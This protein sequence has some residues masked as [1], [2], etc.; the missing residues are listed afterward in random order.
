MALNPTNFLDPQST[1]ATWQGAGGAGIPSY[2]GAGFLY[3]PGVTSSRRPSWGQRQV[4][5]P[6]IERHLAMTSLRI[7]KLALLM[8]TLP[9]LAAAGGAVR[10]RWDNC[11][12]DAGVMNKAFACNVNTGS[13]I[14]VASL[15]PDRPVLGV[16]DLESRVD[17]TFAGGSVPDWWRFRTTGTCRTSSL[18]V[19]ATTP[20]SAVA[21][22]DWAAGAALAGITSY[23]LNTF[24]PGKASVQ[25]VSGLISGGTADFVTGQEYYLFSLTVNHVKT[26]GAGAC[27]GCNLGACIG[28]Q[29]VELNTPPPVSTQTFFALSLDT[30]WL[31][32]WQGG[33]L[34]GAG[35]LSCAQTTATRTSTWGGVKSLYR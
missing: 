34:N 7:A 4:A 25:V 12:G 24:V 27:A 35:G 11:W 30:D 6:L 15:V 9:S 22:Q 33:I 20:V 19:T 5:L 3:C 1:Q 16:S 28:L 2:L 29:Y 17:L 8:L 14:L 21:C 23:S 13:N 32:T 31:T 10:M 26:V 18:N